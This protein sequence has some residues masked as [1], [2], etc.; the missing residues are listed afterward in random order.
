MPSEAIPWG[1]DSPSRHQISHLFATS[2]QQGSYRHEFVRYKY[3]TVRILF[4]LNNL[5]SLRICDH[6]LAYVQLRS[7][8]AQL[9]NTRR[10]IG[11]LKEALA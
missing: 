2:C 9:R 1:F 8:Y 11:P 10:I 3:G 4:I 7:A 6:S 5:P